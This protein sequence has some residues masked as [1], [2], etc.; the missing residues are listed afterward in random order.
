MSPVDEASEEEKSRKELRDGFV[1][2]SSR[3]GKA[4][5]HVTAVAFY[6]HFLFYPVTLF[7]T[8]IPLSLTKRLVRYFTSNLRRKKNVP[9]IIN[10]ESLAVVL[11]ELRSR[12]NNNCSFC[13]AN[14]EFDNRPDETMELST[15]KKSINDL[16]DYGYR[17][18]IAFHG[19]SEPLLTTNL[20]EYIRYAREQ[21]GGCWL[22]L[23]TNGLLLTVRN[24]E[25]F[26]DAGINELS[27]NWYNDETAIDKTKPLPGK[28]NDIKE[29]VIRKKFSKDRILSGF[30]PH[31]IYKDSIFR[32][33]VF[34]RMKSDVLS[35]QCGASP[36]KPKPKNKELLGYCHALITDL[37]I[38]TNG[39]VG[40]C[41]KD[42]YF[43]SH[44]GN[45]LND[46]VISLWEKKI[47]LNSKLVT[48]GDRNINPL[49]S[50]CDYVGIKEA[51]TKKDFK[52][53]II[54]TILGRLVYSS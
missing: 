38:T 31:P 25:E 2:R 12:C 54:R 29:K 13:A 14:V 37:N 49:C 27:V 41:S 48:E 47:E 24:S 50:N 22:Q 7:I 43:I 39:N 30:G 51:E 34:R 46:N 23:L 28:F 16:R 9:I 3:V 42:I 52:A 44:L 18:R 21:L 20:T 40:L 6:R 35:N 10:Q 8:L 32:Y 19:T 45:V 5:L 1:A 53:R 15:F 26:I 11:F 33:N 4:Q 17:G 36:N